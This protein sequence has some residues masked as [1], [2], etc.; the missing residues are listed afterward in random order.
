VFINGQ[1]D[2]K[3]RPRPIA[4][5]YVD[6]KPAPHPEMDWFE[7][8]DANKPWAPFKVTTGN[9]GMHVYRNEHWAAD[10][11]GCSNNLTFG[12]LLGQLV[13]GFADEGSSC[14]MSLVPLDIKPK[15][16]AKRFL[17]VRMSTTVP[18]T[19][20]RY[21]QVMITT[22][23]VLNPGDVQPLDNVPLHAR[24]GP[25]S[26]QN[27]PAGT[28]QSILVQPFGGYHEL[29]LEFCDRRGWGVSEQCPRAN[30][31]GHHAGSY[32]DTWEAPWLP[33]PLL[34]DMAGF[35]RPVQFDVY[36]STERV[37]VF[38]DDKPAGCAV[39]PAG[40]MPEGDVNVAFR[41]VLYHS[42]IDESVTAADSPHQYL[43]RFSLSFER[44][45]MDDFGIDQD[46]PAPA[47][48]E[49]VMPCATRWYGG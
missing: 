41:D 19:G 49:A 6:V 8:F 46:V 26:F 44:R 21:P 39:L 47:W 11:S 4:R 35:D 9:N 24:L 10:F 7:S 40:R 27:A 2:E 36:A 15:I 37:Y 45:S 25:L 30:I 22:T 14:N 42:G 28:E 31:Y 43:R 38:L 13:T 23:D 3:N 16:A 20:R 34:G 12:P 32:S 29:Q 18:S 1:F 17:H 5:A 33:V 48:N